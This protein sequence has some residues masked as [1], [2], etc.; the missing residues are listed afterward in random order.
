MS[1][2]KR[3][4]PA[5]KPEALFTR[6]VSILEQA[7]GNVVRAVNTKSMDRTGVYV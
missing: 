5:A 3:K 1:K 2:P 7:R 4:V 6:I